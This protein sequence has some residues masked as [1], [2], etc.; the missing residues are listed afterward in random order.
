MSIASSSRPSS[1][2]GSSPVRG[3]KRKSTESESD[4]ESDTVLESSET[5]AEQ[6]SGR[7]EDVDSGAEAKSE[8]GEEDKEE[9]KVLSHKEQRRLKKKLAKENT[10]AASGEAEEPKQKKQDKAKSRSKVNKGNEDDA[11]PKRQNSLWVG[12][13]SYKTTPDSLR[14]FFKDAGEVTRVHMPMQ[15]PAAGDGKEIGKKNKG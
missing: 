13:L 15:G 8:D 10:V 4:E 11:K 14:L 5:R 7:D 6:A 3:K 1:P 2:L 9:V 12:N